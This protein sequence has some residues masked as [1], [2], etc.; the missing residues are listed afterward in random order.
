[1]PDAMKGNKDAKYIFNI[2]S[3]IIAHL[4]RIVAWYNDSQSKRSATQCRLICK[5][6]ETII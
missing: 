5:A 4:D 2:I 3:R 1:M 6:P